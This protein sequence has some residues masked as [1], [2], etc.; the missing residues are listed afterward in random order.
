MVARNKQVLSAFLETHRILGDIPVGG[1]WLDNEA[2][3]TVPEDITVIGTL[4]CVENASLALGFHQA[5]LSLANGHLSQGDGAATGQVNGVY[6]A[7]SVVHAA[8][9]YEAGGGLSS[10]KASDVIM[11]PEGYGVDVDRHR[12]IALHNFY[13]ATGGHDAYAIVFYVQR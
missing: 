6:G 10:F 3:F 11:F 9:V 2:V 8:S 7:L 13:P 12:D 4:L 5:E 1:G